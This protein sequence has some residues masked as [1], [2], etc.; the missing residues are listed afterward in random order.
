MK[1]ANI[2]KRIFPKLSG[3]T[4]Q[5]QA[6]PGQ[7][8][9][10]AGGYYYPVDD[11]AK[12]ERFLILGTESGTYYANPVDLTKENAEIV[13]K[14]LVSDGPRVVEKIVEISK[15]GRAPKND[16]ALLALALAASA[17]D[18]ATRREALSV[19]SQV[20]RT[21]THL[22][23]F[24]SYVNCFRGWGRGLRRAVANW[25]I[26]KNQENLSL[27]VVKY[28]QRDSWSLR[29]LL[30]LSHP[31][32]LDEAKIALFDWTCHPEKEE[33][34]SSAREKFRL[35]EG[36]Y[37]A[38][39][40]S[41]HIELAEIIRKYSLPR[42]AVPTDYLNYKEVWD[43]LLVD[44]PIGAMIRNLGKMSNVGLLEPFSDAN[45]YVATRLVDKEQL[46]KARI[47]PISLLLVL[48][49]YANG[50]GGKGSLKWSP[51]GK[52]LEALNDSFDKSFETVEPTGKKILVGIDV[53]GSM[54]G[55]TCVG[56]SMLSSVE[57]AIAVG[58]LFVRTEENVHTMAFDT[59]SYEFPITAKQRLDDVIKNMTKWGGG[60]DLSIP[61]AYALKKNLVVDA[62]VIIT[63]NET[64]AG[65]SHAVQVLYQ[66]RKKINP[67]AKLI[68]LATSASRGS[69]C[70]PNDG[71]SLGVA[72]FDSSVPLLVSDFIRGSM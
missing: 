18:L 5:N 25:F 59:D 41:D 14:L 69:I 17:E 26:D 63:D 36:K 47:H 23:M 52:I 67:S 42:E 29:D 61:I 57:A 6:L 12:L 58:M 72:G 37:Q 7:I 3:S 11:F 38:K 13:S 24:A 20:A 51:F 50:K 28:A 27:Q 8:A 9:N 40:A 10:D 71:L 4:P 64:W 49:T 19:L 45:D 65:K 21:G 48:K 68:V 16:P 56:S 34:I 31:S 46:K 39:Q 22:L 55:A 35:I 66:Y 32:T 30:R 33:A 1:Y 53:S 15:N 60:T 70:D 54:T 2:L 62:F 44:M 43:A